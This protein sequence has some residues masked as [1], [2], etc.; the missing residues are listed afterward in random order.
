MGPKSKMRQLA[1]HLH[2]QMRVTEPYTPWQNL[3]NNHIRELEKRWQQTV[4]TK[5]VHRRLWDYG[6]VWECEIMNC[7]ARGPS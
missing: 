6:L 2:T 5:K 7:I 4:R 1:N 3:V